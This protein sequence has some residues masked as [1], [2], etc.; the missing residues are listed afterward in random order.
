MSSVVNKS[1]NKFVPKA[2]VRPRPGA[3]AHSSPSNP[4]PPSPN[5]PSQS[6]EEPLAPPA[7]Q[8]VPELVVPP[9]PE[10]RD[11]TPVA[12]HELPRRQVSVPVIRT[13][14]G[15]GIPAIRQTNTDASISPSRSG[16]PVVQS[17]S[18]SRG[19]PK[20]RSAAS[21]APT[22]Q[23]SST[24]GSPEASRTGNTRSNS[25][26]ATVLGGTV[27]IPIFRDS[28]IASTQETQEANQEDGPIAEPEGSSENIDGGESS[29][30]EK[31]AKAPRKRKTKAAKDG[32][33]KK[34]RATR[35]RR[36]AAVND[37]DEVQ[38]Q[39]TQEVREEQNGEQEVAVGTEVNAEGVVSDSS[40]YEDPQQSNKP[41]KTRRP[42]RPV[43]KKPPKEPGEKR[44][45]GRRR[46]PSPEDGE[47]REITPSV[48]KMKDLCRDIRIGRKSKRFAELEQMDLTKLAN[49][50]N[51]AKAALEAEP[52]AGEEV[53]QETAEER[54]ERLNNE[55]QSLSRTGAPQMRM[56][57][58]E[59]VLDQESIHVNSHE[60]DPIHE[61]SMEVVE[62]NM[63]FRRI[64][65]AT[66][67]K[68]KRSER[69]DAEETG[70]FFNAL[71]MFG[72]DFEI[73]SKL[74]AG[75]NRQ[76]LRK[77]FLN[78]ERKDPQRITDALRTRVPINVAEY[79][80]MTELEIGDPQLVEDE[81][82]KIREAHEAEEVAA[83]GHA[84]EMERERQENA[85]A[86]M[87][88]G[89]DAAAAAAADQNKK[90][91][92]KKGTKDRGGASHGGEEILSMSREEY[93]A[94]RLR[95]LAEAE[96]L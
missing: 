88:A 40:S 9:Q 62:E 76:Q 82:E 94:E 20:V 36:K 44:T 51:G 5:K 38:V 30:I 70:K 3:A 41:K 78:E 93:E 23:V 92:K 13:K 31:T 64:T 1:K 17:S 54:I 4:T 27:D 8:T 46:A 12:E 21:S 73:V 65:S 15:N 48:M 66:Y 45:G 10:T 2:K 22:I 16:I 67:S 33:P 29:T 32:S 53:E 77:K 24:E 34:R 71:S 6:L 19:I 11:E 14:S 58:G 79:S 61:E 43:A 87:R 57:N 86:A 47:R 80:E 81:L 7:P 95:E 26:L 59:L 49:D 50:Q 68:H 63:A 60:L 39:E 90:G 69:W 52:T 42:R 84:A 89:D 85:N 91:R 96:E 35:G 55:S 37:N 75:R 25:W 18:S 74:F 83:I 72:T 56:V 28:G